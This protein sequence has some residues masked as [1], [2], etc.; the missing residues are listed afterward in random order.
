M[1][2]D[3]LR[4]YP[5][6]LGAPIWSEATGQSS[7]PLVVAQTWRGRPR[8]GRKRPTPDRLLTGDELKS[9]VKD[10]TTMKRKNGAVMRV[11]KD[12]ARVQ[13]TTKGALRQL[14]NDL[15]ARAGNDIYGWSSLAEIAGSQAMRKSLNLAKGNYDHPGGSASFTPS[16]FSRVDDIKI[17]A[18]D[19]NAPAETVGYNQRTID[20]ML[21]KWVN[22]IINSELKQMT[23]SRLA[24]G[25]HLPPD[26]DVRFD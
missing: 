12:G 13:W 25:L 17:K 4:A 1:P 16:S 11:R 15:Q 22:D 5:N 24:K 26:V 9:Y 14:S 6:D 20:K 2:N 3:Y 21:P 10:N 23:P 8:K 19:N 18:E 7:L